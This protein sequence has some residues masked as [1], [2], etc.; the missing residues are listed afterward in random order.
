MQVRSLPPTPK[1]STP[2]PPLKQQAV[3]IHHPRPDPAYI[4]VRAILAALQAWLATVS[5]MQ[6]QQQQR[7]QQQSPL[8]LPSSSSSLAPSSQQQQQQEDGELR[9]LALC[10]MERVACASGLLSSVL[11][12]AFAVLE[13]GE[14]GMG[15][16][17]PT[18]EG[19]EMD[20]EEEVD[21]ALAEACRH[22]LECVEEEER[23]AKGKMA[24]VR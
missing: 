6:Q 22:L 13:E 17:I 20:E 15:M 19:E 10:A 11:R 1:P 18:S 4:D 24:Q 7:R 21:P 2:N 16:M 5:R 23:A 8:P 9:R 12:F 14:E 3:T